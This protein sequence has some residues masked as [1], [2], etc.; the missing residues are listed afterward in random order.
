[1][2]VETQCSKA[3][4]SVQHGL[5]TWYDFKNYE[6]KIAAAFLG[7]NELKGLAIMYPLNQTI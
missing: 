1:M 3:L 5:V 2:R 7:V 4:Y 6:F